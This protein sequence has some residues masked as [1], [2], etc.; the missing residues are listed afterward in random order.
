MSRLKREDVLVLVALAWS[1][2]ACEAESSRAPV[3]EKGQAVQEGSSLGES[4]PVGHDRPSLQPI[5]IAWQGSAK[6]PRDVFPVRIVNNSEHAYEVGLH[7]EGEGPGVEP[8]LEKFSEVALG[9]G[10][11][12][13]VPIELSD[14]PVQ[15]SVYPSSLR[16]IARYRELDAS[17]PAAPLLAVEGERA[18]FTVPLLVTSN[19][20]FKGAVARTIAEQKAVNDKMD[21]AELKELHGE[22]RVRGPGGSYR[23]LAGAE[24]GIV[25]G[26]KLI[27]SVPPMGVDLDVL[28]PRTP[29]TE[30]QEEEH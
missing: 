8:R 4:E 24:S 22:T 12:R 26:P 5:T 19:A 2:I 16:V 21:R 29:E 9:S 6:G 28:P 27:T 25:E 1:A 17:A 23:V 20:D 13:V 7:L 11:E 3:V 14:L 15:S 30:P 10:E 18:A